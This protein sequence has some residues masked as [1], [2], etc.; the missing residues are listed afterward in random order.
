MKISLI[1]SPGA[2]KSTFARQ[3][4]AATDLP[5]MS[6]DTLWHRLDYSAQ[7]RQQ[8]IQQQQDF[9]DIH[10]SWVI[11]GNYYDTIETRFQHSDIVVWFQISR[12]HAIWRVVRRSMRFRRDRQTRPEMPPQ[13]HE[14]F[15]RDYLEFMRF[16]WHYPTKERRRLQPVLQRLKMTN[17]LIIVRDQVSRDAVLAA[18]THN[19]N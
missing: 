13:F 14:Q 11:D 12:P 16:V 7:A 4:A 19:L 15:D 5:L 9:I 18:L 6:L 3:L 1:G 10:A 17:K 8:F 2:G